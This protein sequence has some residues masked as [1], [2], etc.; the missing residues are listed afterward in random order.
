M[1]LCALVVSFSSSLPLAM[2]DVFSIPLTLLSQNVTHV[3]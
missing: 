1:L 3:E 2:M